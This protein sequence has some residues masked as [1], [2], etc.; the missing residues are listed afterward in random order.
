MRVSPSPGCN[1][2][3]KS[4]IATIRREADLKTVQSKAKLDDKEV[5]ILDTVSVPINPHATELFSYQSQ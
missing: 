3:V 2:Q 1:D 5:Q 4:L